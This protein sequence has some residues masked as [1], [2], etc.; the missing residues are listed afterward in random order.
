MKKICYLTLVLF[1]CLHVPAFAKTEKIISKDN[2]YGG[3]TKEITYSDGDDKYQ[4]GIKRI[5]ISQDSKG[6]I[7]RLEVYANESH[8]AKEGWYKTVTYYWERSRISEAYSTDADSA[9]YGFYK[10]VAYFDSNNR[11]DKREYYLKEDSLAATFGVHKRVVYYDS[12]GR[13]THVED[14]DKFGSLLKIE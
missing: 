13:E 7:K 12:N 14:F 11:L 6:E 4:K 1:F 9:K 8:S 3:V 2:E 5:I 10:M